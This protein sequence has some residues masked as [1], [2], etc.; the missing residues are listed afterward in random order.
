MLFVRLSSA[1][2]LVLT[3][4]LGC[5]LLFRAGPKAYVRVWGQLE[6][7]TQLDHVVLRASVCVRDGEPETQAESVSE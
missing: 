1:I 2:L 6:D 4:N 3:K 7:G 5:P